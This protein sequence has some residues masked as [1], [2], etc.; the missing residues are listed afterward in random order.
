M[1]RAAAKTIGRAILT[2]SILAEQA[3]VLHRSFGRRFDGR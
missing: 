2:M 1:P 3:V